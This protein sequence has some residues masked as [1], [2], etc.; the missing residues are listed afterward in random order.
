MT[1]LKVGS[2]ILV[3]GFVMLKGLEDGQKYRVSM[4]LYY[5]APTYCFRKAR[6]KKV[7]CCHYAHD[8]DLWIGDTNN[9]NT[10]EVIKE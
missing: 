3:H 10:I 5:K 7:V 2:I 8:V 9:L 4:G 6:G 1:K